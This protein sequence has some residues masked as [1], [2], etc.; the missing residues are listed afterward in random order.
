MTSCRRKNR[1]PKQFEGGEIC[2][3]DIGE[4]PGGE[5]RVTVPP[6]QNRLLLFPS[7][8]GHDVT[9]VQVASRQFADSRFAVNC[10]M[11]REREAH[12]T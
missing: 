9:S 8:V 3:Y 4:E 6:L 2:L 5:R 11:H 1:E 7:W 12:L 10:W